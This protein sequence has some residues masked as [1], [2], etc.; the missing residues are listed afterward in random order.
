MNNCCEKK[1][2]RTEEEK[3]NLT[4][5]L[6]RIIGQLEGIKRMINDD[7]YCQD[8]LTQLAASDKAL[9]NLSALIFEKH[10]NSC[11]INSIKEGNNEVTEEVI[12]LFKR[13]I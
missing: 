10:I 12:D 2:I 7:R 9:R 4:N 5:R 6:N 13:F 3:K 8:I 11:I 1:K